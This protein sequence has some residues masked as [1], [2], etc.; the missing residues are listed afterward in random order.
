MQPCSELAELLSAYADGQTVPA[1]TEFIGAH[2]EQCGRCRAVVERHLET[3]RLVLLAGDDDWAPPDL[4]LRVARAY[5]G[6]APGASR[7][8]F[9]ASVAISVAALGC[10]LQ[11]A[12]SHVLLRDASTASPA[13]ST[14]VAWMARPGCDGCAAAIRPVQ[15]GHQIT[16]PDAYR[17][18]AALTRTVVHTPA[19]FGLG[20]RVRPGSA[21]VV[22]RPN[23]GAPPKVPTMRQRQRG[24]P[25][26]TQL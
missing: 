10:M 12:S 22:P 17:L 13:T 19:R 21:Y 20:P 7:H 5:S 3:A 15:N 4:R 14:A 24:Q 6:R 1:Q 26:A 8:S 25:L 18:A 11:I 23:A 16:A 2:L 9:L